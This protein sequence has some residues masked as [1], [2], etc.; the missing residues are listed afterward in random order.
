MTYTEI[1]QN[2]LSLLNEYRKDI[3]NATNEL[4]EAYTK[5]YGN[6]NEFDLIEV[7]N[8]IKLAY[9][10]GLKNNKNKEK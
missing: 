2:W 5:E 9:C 8:F 6:T 7:C 10:L 4:V 3:D 1:V